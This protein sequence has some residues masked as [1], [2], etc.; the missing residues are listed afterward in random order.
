MNSMSLSKVGGLC[1]CIG[2]VLTTVPFLFQIT[3]GGTPEE[4]ALILS[5]IH[6]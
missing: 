3:L 1:L 5:L 4:G 6:I 2:A